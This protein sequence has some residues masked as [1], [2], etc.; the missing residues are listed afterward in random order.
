LIEAKD[1]L[2][3]CNQKLISRNLDASLVLQQ[4]LVQI[5]TRPDS[6]PLD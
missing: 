1:L 3:Q 4:T 6:A 2:L 5:V